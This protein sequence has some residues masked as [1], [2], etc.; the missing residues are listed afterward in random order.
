MVC[1]LGKPGS[2][3]AI[4]G[5]AHPGL[6]LAN[7]FFNRTLRRMPPATTDTSPN[8]QYHS[9]FQRK[10]QI[11]STHRM[12]TVVI[13]ASADTHSEMQTKHVVGRQPRLYE[14]KLS[15]ET[16]LQEMLELSGDHVLSL[17]H[18]RGF[19][20]F[21]G[22]TA[23]AP[24]FDRPPPSLAARPATATAGKDQSRKSS[25]CSPFS[26][27]CRRDTRCTIRSMR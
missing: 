26:P 23:P 17:N 3:N 1:P 12:L 6:A 22:R 5:S 14:R 20:S 2:V 9:R 16:A 18:R 19:A 27:S 7:K 10:M 25:A 11:M 4:N 24:A 8:S 13:D 15:G 21:A